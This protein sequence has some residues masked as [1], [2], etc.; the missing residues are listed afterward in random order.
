MTEQSNRYG[1]WWGEVLLVL[2]VA[3]GLAAG[4]ALAAFLL[5]ERLGASDM[6]RFMAATLGWA[7]LMS[8]TL[9]LVGTPMLLLGLVGLPFLPGRRTVKLTLTAVGA[10]TWTAAFCILSRPGLIELP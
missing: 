6:P 3:P 4:V 9:V 8:P 7:V 10:A 2:L 5:L 1:T